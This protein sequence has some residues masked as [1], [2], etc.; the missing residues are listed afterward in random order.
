[1]LRA[2]Q[3][4]KVKAGIATAAVFIIGLAVAGLVSFFAMN[5]I[6]EQSHA[7]HSSSEIKQALE[8]LKDVRARMVVYTN[9]LSRNPDIV[10]ATKANDAAALESVAVREFKALKAVDP[11]VASLEMTDAKGIVVIR[12][13]RPAQKGDD[14][15]KLPQIKAALSGQIASGLTVSPSSGEAAEDSVQPIKSDGAIVGTLK[16]GS[17]FKSETA[18]ELKKKTGLEIVFL[19]GGKV[20]E[21]T[22]GKNVSVPC[23]PRTSRRRKRESSHLRILRSAKRHTLRASCI[24]RATPARA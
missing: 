4:L 18:E 16:I 17:Y 5:T 20:T 19:G 13:H 9:V 1:M 8:T 3:S 10:A 15:G 22:F 2:L 14:K 24:C 12:G 23:L 21:S 6:S 7:D 11:T